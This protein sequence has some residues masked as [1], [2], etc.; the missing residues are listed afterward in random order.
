MDVVGHQNKSMKLAAV[1]L[2][3]DLEQSEVELIVSSPEEASLVV[4]TTLGDV[5]WNSTEIQTCGAWH[6]FS[7]NG[8][9]QPSRDRSPSAMSF[10]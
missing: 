4:V 8:R 10:F 3:G 6:D 9:V 7:S 5:L 1:P 2:A